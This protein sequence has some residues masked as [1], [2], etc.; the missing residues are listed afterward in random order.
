MI[1]KLT[2]A[3]SF[4]FLFSTAQSQPGAGKYLGH[5]IKVWG[6]FKY[7]H[8]A[9][10]SGKI[11]ADS[12]FLEFAG[13]VS[14][15]TNDKAYRQLLF[16]MQ[17]GLGY[18]QPVAVP[19]NT[20][21]LFTI[22]D[23]TA[24]IINDKL[25]PVEIR[26]QMQLLRRQGYT[27]SLHQYMPANF[28]GTDIPAEK[29][30]ADIKYPNPCYQLLALARYW[31]AIEYLFPYK[32]MISKNWDAVLK[33]QVSAFAKPMTIVDFEQHLLQL[34]AAIEDSH[35]GIVAIKQSGKIYG[36]WFPPFT[37]RFAGDSI[38]VTDYIDS[39]SC[40]AQDIRKGDVIIGINGKTIKQQL[41]AKE[42]LVSAS[43]IHKKKSLLAA[44]PLL[45]PL[46]SMDSTV[47]IRL[48]RNRQ[49]AEKKLALQQ[50]VKKDVIDNINR[51]YQK[52]YGYPGRTQNDFILHSVNND[53][54]QIDAAGLSILFN[55]SADD[56]PVDS[57]LQLMRAHKKAILIDMRC[58]ATQAVIYN[59]LLP[60]LG[61]ELK[62]FLSLQA[63]FLRFPGNYYEKD[64]FSL[65]PKMPLQQPYT[66]KVILL[67]N[68]RTHSQSEMITMILQASGPV[69]VV[70]TQTSGA[71]GDLIE[72]PIPGGYTL[73]F[74]GRHV[75]Y[76]DGTA[77][78]KL[79]VK[80]NVKVNET[81]AGIADGKDEILEA[82]LD[83]LK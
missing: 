39:L 31:N 33:E 9:M 81:T 74:S 29:E 43:N 77:S 61:W 50:L 6:F 70:G 83:L 82:A 40:M 64:I 20:T 80:R 69:T 60:A 54:A 72:L 68:E 59:K 55:N 12:L 14:A 28:F 57:V 62:P 38:V 63:H 35:G 76:P 49:P 21:R 56:K 15:V 51:L 3:L 7:Y 58:Y 10:G 44:I 26:K 66:G 32:Y 41:A 46:R 11:D 13:K 24:R 4:I 45:M 79:G 42:S 25:V 78:Q 23:Y 8:P 16:D 34:N 37:F 67:V 71:D 2:V 17:H 47:N 19:K 1:K 5:Y 48:L 75:A 52:Q 30:F 27:D 22:N 36:T 65:V 18:I 53:I 73:I